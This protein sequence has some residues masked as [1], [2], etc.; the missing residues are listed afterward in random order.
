MSIK[1]LLRLR[2]RI[3]P[4]YPQTILVLIIFLSSILFSPY[5]LVS[6]TFVGNND[7]SIVQPMVLEELDFYQEKLD[8]IAGRDNSVIASLELNGGQIETPFDLTS[9]ALSPVTQIDFIISNQ[10]QFSNVWSNPLWRVPDGLVVRI[11]TRTTSEARLD[12]ISNNIIS[13]VEQNY[14]LNLSLYSVQSVSFT[15]TL[16][17]LLAPIT[18]EIALSL[19]SDIFSP[20]DN[21]QN[22][23]MVVLMEEAINHSPDIYAFGYSLQKS[24]WSV[25]KIIRGVMVSLADKISLNGGIY[26]FNLENT[27]GDEIFPNPESFI[28][29]TSFRIPFIANITNIDPI[30]DNTGASVTGSFEWLL[31]YS[32]ITRYPNFNAEISYH[33]SSLADF[34]YPQ[35]VVTNSYSDQILED[36]GVLNMTYRATNIGTGVAL[37]TSIRMPIPAEFAS[38]IINGAEIPVM[39]DDLTINESFSSYIYLDFDYGAYSYEIP[40]LDIQGW[41]QNITT[42][43]LERWQN[44]T[45]IILDEYA[46][47]YCSNGLSSDLYYEVEQEIQTYIVSVGGSEE[48]INNF[49]YY[50]PIIQS[51]LITAVSNTYNTVFS[52]FYENKTLFQ[53]ESTDFSFIPSVF[54]DYLEST[55]PSLGVN[56]TVELSWQITNIPTSS[57][58][59]G[60]FSVYPEY[61]GLYEYAIFRTVESDYKDLMLTLFAVINSAGR[62]LSTFDEVTNS[63]ISLGSRYSYSDINGREYYGLTNGLNLQIGDD[64]AVLESSLILE[65]SI[66]RAGEQINFNLNITNFGSLDA[67]D[68]HVDIVNLKFDFLWQPTGIVKV[69]SFDIDEILIGEELLHEFSIIASSYIGLNTYIALISFT[70]DKDQGIVEIVNPWTGSIIPWIYGGEARNL[71]SSTLTFGILLPPPLLENQAKQ[72]FPLPEIFVESM[73]EVNEEDSTLYLQYEIENIGMSPANISIFQFIDQSLLDSFEANVQY[74]HNEVESDLTIETSVEF[75]SVKVTYATMTLY[76]GDKI[77]ITITGTDLPDNFTVPPLI[78]NYLSLYE[79]LT[80]D[81]QSIETLENPYTALANPLSLKL[82]P[83]IVNEDSQ[84]YFVWSTFSSIFTINIPISDVYDK[85]TYS[86]LPLF[87]PLVS[88]AAITIILSIAMIISKMKNK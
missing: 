15:E 52:E 79:I 75:G 81:F 43:Q 30:P 42:S 77:I 56:E 61:S 13:L 65:E 26:T 55:V 76:P 18:P 59:F 22:G 86:S 74:I 6:S 87:Y 71:V 82:S 69:K 39:K 58:K 83:A 37:N 21:L 31:K 45:E 68:I 53:F 28:S 14:N 54:G 12:D 41:Y 80:T 24:L 10:S 27:F 5:N 4:N 25:N 36:E 88:V 66:Y 63:F 46:T 3:A 40:I 9:I 34:T 35:V 84:N 62:F 16:I 44:D 72:A 78:V 67:Y 7:G 17:S 73:F 20:Y 85:I 57:D 11:K 1:K 64:E 47:I 70:S 23:N 48:V 29:R 33:P 32:H 49:L 60:A 8:L 50:G 51:K 2:N 19:F 38:F